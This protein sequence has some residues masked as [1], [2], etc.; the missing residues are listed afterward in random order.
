VRDTLR[1]YTI[2]SV[3][4]EFSIV[5]RDTN[6]SSVQLLLYRMPP[7]IDSVTTYAD[8]V[9]ATS[10]WLRD[11]VADRPWQEAF[12]LLVEYYGATMANYAAEDE[13]LATLNRG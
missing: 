10:A 9:V 8:A 4:L 13:L 7:L 6:R 2:D 1:V 11:Q 12:P 3:A 5:A